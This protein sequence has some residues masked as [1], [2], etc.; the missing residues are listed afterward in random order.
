MS[1]E[2]EIITSFIG[3]LEAT[4]LDEDIVER[5]ASLLNEVSVPTADE[6]IRIFSDLAGDRSA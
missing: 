1:I 5:V 4:E 6:L 3:R 2:S